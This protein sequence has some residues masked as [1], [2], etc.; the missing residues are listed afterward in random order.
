MKTVKV[1]RVLVLWCT[2]QFD[3]KYFIIK[4]KEN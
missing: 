1:K 3:D 2:D 4:F